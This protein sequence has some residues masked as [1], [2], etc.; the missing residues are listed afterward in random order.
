MA[1]LSI[2]GIRGVRASVNSRTPVHRPRPD[3]GGFHWSQQICEIDAGSF[4]YTTHSPEIFPVYRHPVLLPLG[5]RV[6]SMVKHTCRKLV[7]CSLAAPTA[8]APLPMLSSVVL[9][10]FA[11][12][13]GFRGICGVENRIESEHLLDTLKPV[14]CY[15]I[16]SANAQAA[17]IVY[18]CPGR[19]C[20]NV[21]LMVWSA[22][23]KQ[24]I[25]TMPPGRGLGKA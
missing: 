4:L 13:L 2:S 21:T 15:I 9:P 19:G 16:R 10:V 3:H 1:V 22:P 8:L 18:V 14:D 20:T 12:F 17:N 7:S 25:D 11:G 6:V 24:G 5:P 23:L